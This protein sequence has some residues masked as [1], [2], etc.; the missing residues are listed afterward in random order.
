MNNAII[1]TMKKGIIFLFILAIILAVGYFAWQKIFLP[2]YFINNEN[3]EGSAEKV[4][5]ENWRMVEI[6]PGS[7]YMETMTGAGVDYVTA[8]AIFEASADIYDLSTV[9]AGRQL[10]LM[11]DESGGKLLNLIYKINSEEEIVATL[12]KLEKNEDATGGVVSAAKAEPEESWQVKRQPIPYEV[13]TKRVE[14]T[15]ESSMYEA[16]LKAGIDE[17]VILA[18]AY[19]FQ[20]TIDFA[21]DP[22]VGDKFEFIFEERYLDGE[23][24]I[25]GEVLAGVYDNQGKKYFVYYFEESEE[26]KE[27]FDELG[28]SVQKIFLKAPLDFKYISSGFTSGLRY[29][30]AFNVATG[31]RAVDYAAAAGTPVRSVGDGTVVFVGWDA[32][33]Y[34]NR[35]G[36]RHNETYATNYG[37]LS[38][39][40]VKYGAKVKQGQTIGYVGSTGFSTGPHLHYE[41]VKNGVKIN[42]IKEV[43]PPGKP[44]KEENRA[45][46]EAQVAEYNKLLL[47]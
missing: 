36:I 24:I 46:F 7:T 8:M 4:V 31:H 11:F 39:F 19:A 29:V 9:R 14:G 37:H 23:Y 16:G 41:M 18:Y 35:V 45:R 44:I 27:H 42:A 38:K 17:R 2:D 21:N 43:L 6:Q 47:N 30:E 22:R 28:N 15:V 26:N 25:P 10:E 5:K 33:G 3:G 40:A 12:L 32:R 1:Q 34:G 13:K 20:W